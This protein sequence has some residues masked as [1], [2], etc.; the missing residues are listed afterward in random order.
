MK[1]LLRRWIGQVVG[2]SR[3]PLFGRH[4]RA[5]Q[6][7]FKDVA[8]VA[9]DASRLLRVVAMIGACAVRSAKS[10]L[11]YGTQAAL[12]LHGQGKEFLAKPGAAL[13]LFCQYASPY[14]RIFTDPGFV[15]I[16]SRSL[17]FIGLRSF[18]TLCSDIVLCIM[19]TATR[20]N[21]WPLVVRPSLF[22]G[23]FN[24]RQA[25]KTDMLKMGGPFIRGAFGFFL[26][27]SA[28]L[29]HNFSQVS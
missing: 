17:S 25:T 20:F 4:S 3:S 19:R 8:V 29:N 10:A 7:A 13:T 23:L 22:A 16:S 28:G 18:S 12:V 24:I 2:H 15:P 9:Q 1:Q 26:V 14:F 6:H 27:G 21:F 11:T 5:T